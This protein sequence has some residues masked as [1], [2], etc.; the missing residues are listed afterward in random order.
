MPE[1]FPWK[2]T[3]AKVR[4]AVLHHPL[5]NFW[6]WLTDHW[7]QA[8]GWKSNWASCKV[9]LQVLVLGWEGLNCHYIACSILIP[10]I[11]M[12]PAQTCSW[13]T[14]SL[15][16]TENYFLLQWF[17]LTVKSIFTGRVLK[18]EFLRLSLNSILCLFLLN[19]KHCCVP[20]MLT[21]T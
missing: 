21:V 2:Y 18:G 14:E 12:G 10:T 19:G 11:W 9:Q 1:V 4:F 13:V 7:A 6:Q 3:S 20:Q 17:P 16:G 15:A 8:L 5:L